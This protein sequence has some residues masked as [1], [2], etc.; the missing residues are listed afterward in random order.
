MSPLEK[1]E[2]IKVFVRRK[3]E[4]LMDKDFQEMDAKEAANKIMYQT[5]DKAIREK[6]SEEQNA[7]VDRTSEVI[8]VLQKLQ[9]EVNSGN[10]SNAELDEIVSS[11][12]FQDYTV[13]K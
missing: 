4:F 6:L 5:A 7:V 3:T 10:I 13:T 12:E 8:S 9:E 2:L 11:K 1:F